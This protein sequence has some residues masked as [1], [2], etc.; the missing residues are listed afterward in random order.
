MSGTVTVD[1]RPVAI[2]DESNLL[3]LIRKANIDIP[4]FCYHSELST[5]G[6]C[7]LCLVEI[8]GKK[9]DASCVVPPKDGMSVRTSTSQIRTMRKMNLE[10]I[11][12]NHK[13]ECPSCTRSS[14]CKLRELSAKLG[15]DGTRFRRT[16]EERPV[17]QGSVALERDPNKCI[18]CGDCVRYCS[19]VQSIGALDFAYRGEDVVVT[20][21]FGK[22]LGD[23]DCVSCGQCAA[24]C[25]TAAIV[26][27]SQTA[28]VWEALEDPRRTLV[29]QI[30]PAVRVALGE[31]FGLGAD[32]TGKIVR[33][34][35]MLGFDRVY[36]T[37]FGADLT[38]LEESRELVERLAAAGDTGR[39]TG[40]AGAR[41]SGRE[42]DTADSGNKAATS[43]TSGARFPMF[44]SCCP[45]WVTFAEQNFPELLPNLSTCMSP[46]AMVGSLVKQTGITNAAREANAPDGQQNI[47]MVSIMPCT[48][49]KAEAARS[50]LS[51]NGEPFV[52]HVVT[53]AELGRMIQEAGIRF[54]DLEPDAMDLP[55]GVYSGAG[56][57][58]GNSGG[59]SEAVIRHVAEQK[60]G[61]RNATVGFEARE[62]NPGIRSASVQLENGQEIRV[63]VVQGLRNARIVAEEAQ[64][65][66]A[67]FDLIEVMACPG[68]CIGGAGQPI[69][70][71]SGRR[72]A[73]SEA[74]TT[75]DARQPLRRSAE[76]PF[77]GTVY[78][79]HVGGEAG[80]PEAHHLL[81]THYRSKQRIA[82]TKIALIEGTHHER[83][84]VKVCVGTSCFLSGSQEV[85]EQVG[86]V[87]EERGLSR[88]VDLTATFCSESCAL[89]PTV[90]VGEERLHRATAEQVIAAVE[91]QV[92]AIAAS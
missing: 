28:A 63:G 83:V 78:A 17:D 74:L 36:D 54:A 70:F 76:N 53:T 64:R 50:E 23:V 52:D 72:N 31:M 2:E 87:L 39:G 33:A 85:L 11:L 13:R 12:A 79:E 42:S 62:G 35:R 3:A 40:A 84:P 86:T 29:A 80:S 1:G 51:V 44:T 66:E 68:G 9:V 21:A 49:K 25:P 82:E 48:A 22:S 73:R 32:Q 15:V 43:E 91:R 34:L 77:V 69:G 30:A 7:R 60:D 56:V 10:L 4:T 90:N 18:L 26:P 92:S 58:F 6:A 75:T 20:P 67:P 55:M 8:D 24:V 27:K 89:G 57:I 46:Q 65:G 37:S 41:G 47:T 61:T 14:D 19:E 88:F 38:V 5:Y 45:A 81:H 71:S 59:V 16:R